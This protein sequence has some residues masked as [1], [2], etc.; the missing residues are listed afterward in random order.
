MINPLSVVLLSHP[1]GA[2]H[3]ANQRRIT[4]QRKAGQPLPAWSTLALR[5]CRRMHGDAFLF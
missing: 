2:V 5:D 3:Y 4:S 1:R